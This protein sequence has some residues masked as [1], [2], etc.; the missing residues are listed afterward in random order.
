MNTPI[1]HREKA[2]RAQDAF[3]ATQSMLIGD[4][5]SPSLKAKVKECRMTSTFLLEAERLFFSQKLK[6]RHLLL[7]D[8]CTTYFHSLVKK[9]N[10]ASTIPSLLKED[11]SPTTSQ[12]EVI[13]EFSNFFS[14]LF[15]SDHQLVTPISPHIINMGLTIY[16]EDSCL[17]AA[18]I[19]DEEIK[20]ALFHIGD[21][22]AP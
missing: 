18:H 10:S 22:K 21:D 20:E 12:E 15:C 7:A 14:N 11:G 19:T 17:L 8:R 5:N 16:A 1:S 2:K 6:N 4:P 3:D 9:R 13:Q